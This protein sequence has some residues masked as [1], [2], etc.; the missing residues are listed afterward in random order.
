MRKKILRLLPLAAVLLSASCTD[1]QY[2]LSDINTESRFVAQGLV[3]PLNLDPVKLDAVISLKDDSD[4]K[5][6]SETGNYYF[7]K[8]GQKEMGKDYSF[9]SSDVYVEKITIDKPTEISESVVLDIALS[10][11]IMNKIEQYASDK[12]IGQILNDPALSF[13]IGIT[14]DTEVFRIDINDSKNFNL[15]ATGIDHRITKLGE[16]GFDQLKLSINVK[17]DGLKD[18]VSKVNINNLKIGLP[19]GLTVTDNNNY[20]IDTGKLSYETLQVE[21]GKKTIEATVTGMTYAKMAADGALFSAEN[22]TFTYPKQCGVEGN[23]VVKASD[24]NQNAK[25]AE[26]K[27]AKTASYSCEVKF[28]NYIV[29]N[30]FSGGI[31]YSIGDI[32]IDPVHIGNLP[33]ILKES[34][35]NIELENPQLYLSINNP[36][37]DNNITAQAGLR[38]VGNVPVPESAAGKILTFDKKDNK[39]ALSPKNEDLLP[40]K[41]EE[42]YAHQS[43]TKMSKLL[44][45]VSGDPDKDKIPE[46]LNISIVTPTLNA[47]DVKNFTLGENHPGITGN[48]EFYTKLSL[49]ENSVIKY[50]KEWDDWGNKD[51]DGLTVEKAIVSFT[52]DKDVAVDADKIK[53]TLLGKN[54]QLTGETPLVGDE[55]QDI[56][57]EMTGDPVSQIYGG[58]IEVILKGKGKPLSAEQKLTVNNLRIKV[59]G[60]YDRK[61]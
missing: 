42:G 14:P 51:L 29:V 36:F 20:N 5:K 9:H 57:M 45:G 28:S 12:T 41:I 19:A 2:N 17:L 61:L 31:N 30:S 40:E 23:A 8:E 56:E 26:I 48:W 53:F 13:I 54:G 15:N 52:V 22:H 46:T 16:L 18:L 32:T 60:Y 4:I 24:L 59:D 7:K 37:F 38:I 35:T 11:D 49:T 58:K 3:I 33:D 1:S 6:D 21:N 27:N 39:M 44:S 43:F 50:V 55:E 25:L 10:D 47:E 34:G